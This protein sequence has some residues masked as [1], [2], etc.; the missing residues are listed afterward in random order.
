MRIVQSVLWLNALVALLF[1]GADCVALPDS[2]S[3]FNA[4]YDALLERI[5]KREI[6]ADI[7]PRAHKLA[8]NTRKELIEYDAKIALLRERVGKE[9]EKLSSKDLEE[10]LSLTKRREQTVADA[11]KELASLNNIYTI[12]SPEKIS[13]EKLQTKKRGLSYE[14]ITP[15]YDAPSFE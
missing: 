14:I 2:L 7:R 5:D 4:E 12:N 3:Q 15:E 11:R 1:C 9:E 10:L 6:S 13:E 8:V